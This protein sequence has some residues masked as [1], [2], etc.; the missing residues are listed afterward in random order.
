METV[1]AKKVTFLPIKVGNI[2]IAYEIGLRP[3][4]VDLD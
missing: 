4:H 1:K 3:F 2:Y